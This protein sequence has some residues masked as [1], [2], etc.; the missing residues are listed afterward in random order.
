MSLAWDVKQLEDLDKEGR[1]LKITCQTIKDKVDDN[2]FDWVHSNI[3]GQLTSLRK[4]LELY[5]RRISRFRRTPATHVL[6]V[7]ISPEER[8]KKPYAIP[9]QCIPYAGLGDLKLRSIVDK[10]IEQMTTRGMKVAGK[11]SYIVTLDH[12]SSFLL[13]W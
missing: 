6:V 11:M 7:M 2:V 8:N 13:T 3:A 12:Y 10:V 1:K 4:A 5:V 9:I